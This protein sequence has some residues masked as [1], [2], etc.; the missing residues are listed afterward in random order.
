MTMIIFFS[1][2]ELYTKEVDFRVTCRKALFWP[3]VNSNF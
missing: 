1:F 2:N 3:E